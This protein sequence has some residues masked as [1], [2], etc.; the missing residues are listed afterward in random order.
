MGVTHSVSFN[1]LFNWVASASMNGSVIV[2]D[3]DVNR[4]GT[5]RWSEREVRQELKH[6]GGVVQMLWHPNNFVLGGRRR[7]A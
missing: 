2:Y 6:N 5:A 3:Y 1:P 7:E 4:V